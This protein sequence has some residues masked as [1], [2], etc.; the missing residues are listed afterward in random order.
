MAELKESQELE[1][2]V[3]QLN[4]KAQEG[5][6]ILQQIKKKE[7]EIAW[8]KAFLLADQDKER[9]KEIDEWEALTE[10]DES[11]E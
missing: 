10:E 9:Q 1:Q 3:H 2:L 11:N 8:K 6:S 7:R 4:Q 5:N